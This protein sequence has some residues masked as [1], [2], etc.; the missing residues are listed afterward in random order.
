LQPAWERP[1]RILIMSQARR[2]A[3]L[4]PALLVAACLCM[5]ASRYLHADDS[6]TFL[7]ASPA[8]RGRTAMRGFKE[9]FEAW[10]SSLTPEEQE[11]VQTQAAGEFNK[12]FRKSDEFKKDLPEEKVK[13]FSKI[14]G[15]FFDAEAA[16]Y[17]KEVE[18]KVPNYNRLLEKAGDK[19][20][21]SAMKNRIV[22]IDRDADRR[23]TFATQKIKKFEA[24]GEKFP[25]SSPQM[26]TYQLPNNDAASH[27]ALKKLLDEAKAFTDKNSA[28]VSPEVKA[29]AEEAI[30]QGIPPMGEMAKIYLPWQLVNQL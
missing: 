16:D 7:T 14:L 1:F 6:P 29:M 8:V 2:S 11:Q 28:D 22:E 19:V 5:L 18:A 9:D 25:Q 23:Y 30:K 21:D 24:K 27:E 12:K 4:L 15:K 10:R 26:Q 3:P 17:K 20:L 13:S